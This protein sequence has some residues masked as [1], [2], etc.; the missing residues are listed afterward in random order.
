ML[1]FKNIPNI[2]ETMN[3]K[4]KLTISSNNL[5]FQILVCREK[6]ALTD[7]ALQLALYFSFFFRL[8][9]ACVLAFL[10]HIFHLK[11]TA[12]IFAVHACQRYE[13]AV[14]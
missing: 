9:F 1:I 10:T 13:V 7:L 8:A 14:I 6:D 4:K 5:V 11:E 3:K 12:F 2:R